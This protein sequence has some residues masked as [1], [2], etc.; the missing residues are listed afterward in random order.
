[1]Y[2]MNQDNKQI[3]YFYLFIPDINIQYKYFCFF[4]IVNFEN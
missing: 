1:M 3:I 2:H 4:I